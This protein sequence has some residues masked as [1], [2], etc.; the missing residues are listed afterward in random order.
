MNAIALVQALN[1]LLT[2]ATSVGVNVSRMM[3]MREL[4]AD[5]HLSPA[6]V[7]Q[8]AKERDEAVS[9]L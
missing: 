1:A 7:E 3:A 2:L 4:S 9:K 8:L 5:G 6:Q